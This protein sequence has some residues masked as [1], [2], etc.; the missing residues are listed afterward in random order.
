MVSYPVT[1]TNDKSLIHIVPIQKKKSSP[2]TDTL[3]F[4][5]NFLLMFFF[6]IK[7]LNNKLT[8]N[9][10]FPMS[11]HIITVVAEN[12]LIRRP[13]P[14]C[15]LFLLESSHLPWLPSVLTFIFLDILR[16][17]I[18]FFSP[19]LIKQLENY[20]EALMLKHC[21]LVV[22]CCHGAYNNGLQISH[23]SLC[24]KNHVLYGRRGPHKIT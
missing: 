6:W 13:K 21:H 7:Q 18:F 22:E 4:R 19:D 14:Q 11:T 15:K 5:L 17:L 1:L 12:A 10:Q 8:E 16:L 20:F 2:D 9:Q 24:I 23:V 3:R